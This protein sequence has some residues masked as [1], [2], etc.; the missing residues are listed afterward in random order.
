MTALPKS[1]ASERRT[2]RRYSIV[3]QL[4]V[5]LLRNGSEKIRVFVQDISRD[6][7]GIVASLPVKPHE[8]LLLTWTDQRWEPVEMTVI[9]RKEIDDDSGTLFNCGLH[10][11]D[12]KVDL[13]ERARS[14]EHLS[15]DE[16]D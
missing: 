9:W 14:Y 12:P 3:G 11:K 2:Y 5:I 4:P 6:G 1:K 13:E 10:H 16:L 8:K 7:I 15:L